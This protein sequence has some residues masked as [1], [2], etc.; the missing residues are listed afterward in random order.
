M[1]PEVVEAEPLYNFA[2]TV[3]GNTV[4]NSDDARSYRGRTNIIF[5]QL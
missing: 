4:L 1:T 5:D 2:V 3:V